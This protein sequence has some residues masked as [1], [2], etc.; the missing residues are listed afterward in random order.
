MRLLA[1]FLTSDA[2]GDPGGLPAAS[3]LPVAESTVHT[4]EGTTA[5]GTGPAGVS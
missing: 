3:T 2:G 4:V 5:P 1:A